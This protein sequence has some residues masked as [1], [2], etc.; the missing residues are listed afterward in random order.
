MRKPAINKHP[1]RRATTA[2]VVLGQKI[3]ARRIEA[4]MSQEELGNAL[5]VSFQ[6][7]QKYE[8]GV[9]RVSATRLAEIAK[10]LGES[11]DYFTHTGD[12]TTTEMTAMMGDPATQ[13]LV[14]AFHNV[15]S[16]QL[17]YRLVG[18]IEMV[19]AA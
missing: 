11:Q 15:K 10:A 3:R 18:L 17:R 16:S 6:Q 5:G 2:D 9:N 12:K 13:R 7:V 1:M 19:S 14:K 4:A 8:K